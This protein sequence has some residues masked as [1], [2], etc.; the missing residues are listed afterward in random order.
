M[1]CVDIMRSFPAILV[2]LVFVITIGAS[3]GMVVAAPLALLLWAQYVRLVRG[4]C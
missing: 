2:A 4:R 3:F 1:R